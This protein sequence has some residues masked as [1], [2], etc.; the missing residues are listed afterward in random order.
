MTSPQR[1]TTDKEKVLLQTRGGTFINATKLVSAAD[2]TQTADMT[3]DPDSGRVY[4]FKAITGMSNA[5]ALTGLIYDKGGVPGPGAQIK[6]AFDTD[7]RRA[8]AAILL[9][10]ADDDKGL[11]GPAGDVLITRG[12]PEVTSRI[13]RTT[14][15]TGPT[16]EQRYGVLLPP[17]YNADIAVSTAGWQRPIPE[18][19]VCLVD[20]G[21]LTQL[22]LKYVNGSDTYSVT[23]DS[24]ANGVSW[25][26]PLK[27]DNSEIPGNLATGN[28]R[29]E[30]TPASGAVFELYVGV[31]AK[32]LTD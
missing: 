25:Q 22:V 19:L 17:T 12:D 2:P 18:W 5:L 20:K 15:E 28:F 13:F 26:K 11:W 32:W 30:T 31:G 10:H 14:P 23:M 24:L 9:L 29:V 3:S 7:D 6:A 21:N 4:P 16:G 8:L 1:Y 27:S